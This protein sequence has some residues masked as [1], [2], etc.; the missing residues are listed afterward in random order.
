MSGN[1][2]I[3]SADGDLTTYTWDM[4]NRVTGVAL[5]GGGLNT[6]TGVQRERSRR[7][8]DGNSSC[9]ATESEGWRATSASVVRY[10]SVSVHSAR[11]FAEQERRSYEDSVM[12]RDFLWAR[13]SKRSAVSSQS[14]NEENIARQ[15]DAD[16]ATDR[17]YTHN[18]QVGVHP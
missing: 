11:Y 9:V 18:P 13:A 3:I 16:G 1:I 2:E 8:G 7:D 6:M 17:D 15:T 14:S 4:E 12:L 5:P 10:R